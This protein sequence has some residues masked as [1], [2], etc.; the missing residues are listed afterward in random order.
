[1]FAQPK[2]QVE[3][4][5]PLEPID[6]NQRYVF[7]V[8]K[9]EDKGIGQFDDPDD[10]NA[11]H[12]L[13]WTFWVYNLDKSPVLNANN[14]PYEHTQYTSNRTGKGKKT[15]T[16]R[17]WIEALFGRPL[18]DSEIGPGIEHQLIDKVAVGLFEEKEAT[19]RDGEAYNRLSILRLSAMKAPAPEAPKPAPKPAQ[20]PLAEV[21]AAATEAPW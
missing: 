1:M 4:V 3:Y 15:A 12:R 16:A 20:K 13:L 11:A 2:A 10:P 18:E 8:R 9:I 17:L 19:N 14:D 21:V 6:I 7:R 5:S